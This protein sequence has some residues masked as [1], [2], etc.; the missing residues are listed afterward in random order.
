LKCILNDK[1]SSDLVAK[2]YSRVMPM[3]PNQIKSNHSQMIYKV[4]RWPE[5]EDVEIPCRDIIMSVDSA[6]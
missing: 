6:G 1:F 3:A 2:V 4:A 5:E